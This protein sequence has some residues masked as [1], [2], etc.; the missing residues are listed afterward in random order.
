MKLLRDWAHICRRAWS[1]RLALLSAVLSAIEIALPY[2][3]PATPSRRFAA[4]AA[5]LA[6]AAAIARIVAQPKAFQHDEDSDR[7]G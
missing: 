6:L 7:A 3:A 2:F 5:A 4:A 1:V